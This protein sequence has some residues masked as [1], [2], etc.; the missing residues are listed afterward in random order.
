MLLL[1]L[2]KAYSQNL[3]LNP[4]FETLRDTCSGVPGGINDSICLYWDSPIYGTPDYYNKCASNL[5]SGIIGMPLGLVGV[6]INT[7]IIGGGDFNMLKMGMLLQGS[8]LWGAQQ[9]AENIYRVD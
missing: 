5:S 8:F 9:A 7:L 4:S 3:V 1:S 2:N 6:P